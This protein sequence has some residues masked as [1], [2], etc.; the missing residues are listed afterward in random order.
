MFHFYRLLL[1]PF[2]Y[3]LVLN[4][5][6]KIRLIYNSLNKSILPIFFFLLLRL[7]YDLIVM[8]SRSYSDMKCKDDQS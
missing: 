1:K 4:I 7:I 5:E 6:I 8:L 3:L 2:F